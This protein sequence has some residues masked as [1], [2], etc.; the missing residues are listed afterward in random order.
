MALTWLGS[1][2]T[3]IFPNM[4]WDGIKGLYNRVHGAASSNSDNEMLRTNRVYIELSLASQRHSPN[5]ASPSGEIALRLK[6]IFDEMA[7]LSF[8][9][10]SDSVSITAIAE[11]LGHTSVA[12]LEDVVSGKTPLAFEDAKQLSELLGVNKRWLLEGNGEPFTQSRRYRDGAECLRALID[13]NSEP[14]LSA[15]YSKWYFVLTNGSEGNAAVFGQRAE[16][17]FRIELLLAAVPIRG[18]VGGTGRGQIVEFCELCAWINGKSSLQT[19]GRIVSS[20]VYSALVNGTQH[21]QLLLRQRCDSPYWPNDIG[22]L[23]HTAQHYPEGY[24]SARKIFLA[25][26]RERNIATNAALQKHLETRFL[27]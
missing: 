22:D 16:N 1:L 26:M 7:G 13:R 4:L 18:D 19:L 2:L 9:S 17:P 5:E 27:N 15:R 11:M 6:H 3:S 8:G 12:T 25:E 24:F 21:P 10:I 14:S 23:E 20:E